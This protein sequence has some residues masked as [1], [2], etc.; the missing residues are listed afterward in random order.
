MPKNK[1]QNPE[2]NTEMIRIRATPE[3][4][5]AFE[6]YC[7][8]HQISDASGGRLAIFNLVNKSHR[9]RTGKSLPKPD[10]NGRDWGNKSA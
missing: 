8:E 2:A 3:L 10:L 7:A 4:K 1:D 9:Q 5:K 6:Q